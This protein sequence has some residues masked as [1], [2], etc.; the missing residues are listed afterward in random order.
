MVD[1]RA[2]KSLRPGQRPQPVPRM[3]HEE[4]AAEYARRE[5]EQQA[6][7]L[8][9]QA[10]LE[11]AR[12]EHQAGVQPTPVPSETTLEGFTETEF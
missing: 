2:W 5:A 11:R 12:L 10:D 8:Q 1:P 7:R 4:I 9:Q 3:S 6:E